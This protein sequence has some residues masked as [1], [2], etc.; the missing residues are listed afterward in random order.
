MARRSTQARLVLALGLSAAFAGCAPL[1]R[2][3]P[4]GMETELSLAGFKVMAADT[5]EKQKL[6]H[7]LPARSLTR[8]VRPDNVYY[9]YADPDLCACLYVGRETEYDHLTRLGAER[10]IADEQLA[11]NEVA[12]DQAAGWG[13]VGP[14]GNWGWGGAGYGGMGYSGMGYAGGMGPGALGYGVDGWSGAYMRPAW[15]PW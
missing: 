6:L 7:T 10:R 13:P 1:E 8:I 14:W 2:S 5:S 15:D 11:A 3:S 12:Q 9:I 4:R